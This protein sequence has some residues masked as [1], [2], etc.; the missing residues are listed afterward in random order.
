MVPIE[1]IHILESYTSERNDGGV[2]MA[3]EAINVTQFTQFPPRG[4]MKYF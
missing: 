3:H 1:E 2:E 4:S